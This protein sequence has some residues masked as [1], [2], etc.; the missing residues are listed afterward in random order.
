MAEAVL[1]GRRGIRPNFKLY[2]IL[3]A[4]I[5]FV[6]IKAYFQLRLFIVVPLSNCGCQ[7]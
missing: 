7:G 4:V 1:F 5:D 2:L 3:K 6:G